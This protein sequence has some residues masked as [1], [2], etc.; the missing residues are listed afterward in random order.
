MKVAVYKEEYHINLG[1]YGNINPL[2][3]TDAI[4]ISISVINGA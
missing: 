4:D 3:N 2:K 1:A